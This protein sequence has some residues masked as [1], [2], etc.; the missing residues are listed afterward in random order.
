MQEIINLFTFL[1]HWVFLV[2][3]ISALIV[4]WCL[5]LGKK[6]GESFAT[7]FGKVFGKAAAEWISDQAGMTG[8]GSVAIHAVD[9]DG[10]LI[11]EVASG[12]LLP[13]KLYQG[14]FRINLAEFGDVLTDIE[15]REDYS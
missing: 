9:A 3:G 8:A 10:T 14:N 1:Y 12:A 15:N 6:A 2:V 11:V 7:E 13:L 4:G 5:G